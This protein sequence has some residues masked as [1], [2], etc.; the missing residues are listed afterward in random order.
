MVWEG[1]GQEF[2]LHAHIC[3]L[4]RGFLE[5]DSMTLLQNTG[6]Q[7]QN[8]RPNRLSNTN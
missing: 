5:T 2:A 8:M 3:N 1:I 6:T 4:G 7:G